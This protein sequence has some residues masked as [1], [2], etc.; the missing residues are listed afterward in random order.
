MW[1]H[2]DGEEVV[3]HAS[4]ALCAACPGSRRDGAGQVVM[5]DIKKEEDNSPYPLRQGSNQIG[6]FMPA[7]PPSRARHLQV[8]SLTR[9]SS[10]IDIEASAMAKSFCSVSVAKSFVLFWCWLAS[11]WLLAAESFNFGE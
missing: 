5:K 11:G 3:L 6:G 1:C 7:P 10:W 9:V 2:G 4:G 8:F